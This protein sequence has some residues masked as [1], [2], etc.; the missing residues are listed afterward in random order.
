MN[1]L[2]GTMKPS[3]SATVLP[4]A[5]KSVKEVMLAP[6]PEDDPIYERLVQVQSAEALK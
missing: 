4:K 6:P 2:M 1:S 3:G 5:V